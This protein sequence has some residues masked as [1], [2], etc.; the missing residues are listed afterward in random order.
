MSGGSSSSSSTQ[1]TSQYYDQRS[2]VDA[3]G[4]IVGTGNAWDQSIHLTDNS[5]KTDSGAF[6]VVRDIGALQADM[7]KHLADN[8]ASMTSGAFDLA[9][10]AQEGAVSSFADVLDLTKAVVS[11][12]GAQASTAAST[13]AAAYQSAA[14]TSSGNKTLIYAA[15]AA[16]AVVGLAVAFRK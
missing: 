7:A 15:L 16:V 13:A 10:N 3:G 9:K 8:G 2:V 14:D 6:G 12:A 1:N 11:Q 5:T 4:G